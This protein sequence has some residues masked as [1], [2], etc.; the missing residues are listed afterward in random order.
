MKRLLMMC[1]VALLTAG[2]Q[3]TGAQSPAVTA[4]KLLAR[5]QH[6]A[7]VDRDL[8]GAIEDYKAA[9]AA[10][11]TNRALAARA[12]VELAECYDK[13]GERSDAVK[14][15][16]DVLRKYPD[17]P[18]AAIA[19]SRAQ[20]PQVVPAGMNARL[21]WS[22]PA[23]TAFI[24]DVSPDD[25]Y[26][27]YVQDGSLFVRDLRS[28]DSTRLTPGQDSGDTGAESV[29]V[30]AFS[31]D[32]QDLAFEVSRRGDSAAELRIQPLSAPAGSSRMIYKNAD[33]TNILPFDWTPDKK[34]LAVELVRKD[35]TVQIAMLSPETGSL[36][37][38]KSMEWRLAGRMR[39]SPDGAY[40]AVDL[41]ESD[42][43]VDRDV[44]VLAVDGSREITAVSGRGRDVLV[45]W[46]TRGDGLVFESSRGGSSALYSVAFSNG[47]P[48][49]APTLIKGDLGRTAAITTTPGGRLYYRNTFYPHLEVRVGSIDWAAGRFGEESR[50]ISLSRHSQA[51]AADW[52][53]DGRSLAY[54]S[55]DLSATGLLTIA[56][57]R[58][59]IH[60]MDTGQV[61]EL[62]PEPELDFI[63][64][65]RWSP[66][67]RSF[68]VQGR[69]LKGRYGLFVIDAK[70]GALQVVL[71]D[72]PGPSISGPPEWSADGRKL[73]FA[74]RLSRPNVD[75]AIVELDVTT[76]A[77]RE[78]TRMTQGAGQLIVSPDG[79]HLVAGNGLNGRVQA[80]KPGLV[81]ISTA[82][83][84]TKE[85]MPL[86]TQ[87][88]FYA[89][90]GWDSNG[91][92]ILVAKEEKDAERNVW[93]VPIDGAEPARAGR[94]D[95]RPPFRLHPDGQRVAF[96]WLN[97]GSSRRPIEVWVLEN[98]LPSQATSRRQN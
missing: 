68:A 37:V 43:T 65:L 29:T 33:V 11:G 52:S 20:L 36:R 60:S 5:A 86:T 54:V 15:Y 49:G 98:Y 82:D 71:M 45:G 1:A 51:S 27:S 41:P 25:R 85:L 88:S 74:R 31:R 81:L 80:G 63:G 75:S 28:G 38:L 55:T 67:G 66:D 16:R 57:Y 4:E 87:P 70:T 22:A 56:S 46:T 73:Y 21:V 77:E 17:A 61:Q 94:A 23:N 79:R 44:F 39:L 35:R 26:I 32:S 40:L 8:P 95:G 13:L 59:T 91:R 48:A 69:T 47:R 12:L 62:K 10:A 96:D 64:S 7:A 78:L 34:L 42:V 84:A 89:L 6:K 76:H 53:P 14:V 92:S 3:A 9:V 90:V 58:V 2:L 30:S 50:A 93:R 97:D 24:S 72:D 19:Q 18:A 83:G